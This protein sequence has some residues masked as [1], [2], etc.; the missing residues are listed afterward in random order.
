MQAFDLVVRG[1]TV[2]TATDV[3]Q[4]DLAISGE[5]IAAI[6]RDL[7]AGQREIDARGKLVLPGGVD[8]HACNCRTA[9][10][11]KAVPLWVTR[12][13]ASSDDRSAAVISLALPLLSQKATDSAPVV[14]DGSAPKLTTY[15]VPTW[16]VAASMT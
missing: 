10:G 4:A 13:R 15:I 3:M 12:F 5:T 16:E 6:G 2:A 11:S 8:S 14:L 7:P 1:G 9:L